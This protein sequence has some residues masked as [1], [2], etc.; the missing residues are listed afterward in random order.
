MNFDITNVKVK[1]ITEELENRFNN[2]DQYINYISFYDDLDNYEK[3]YL[4][5]LLHLQLNDLFSFLNSKYQPNV[6]G[7][8]NAE[9]SRDLIYISNK[10]TTIINIFKRYERDEVQL[11][12]SYLKALDHCKSF[13]RESYG[14]DIPIN[15]EKLHLIDYAPIFHFNKSNHLKT[16]NQNKLKLSKIG[17]GSYATVYK[18]KD[19]FYNEKFALKRAHKDLNTSEKERFKNEFE[20]LSKL[21]SP[22][23]IKAYNYF[24]EQLEYVME[25]ADITL[26][27]Y[28]SINNNKLNLKSRISLIKQ[29]LNAFKYLHSEKLLH[30]DISYN[31][32]LLKE[33]SD[34]TTVL[35]VSDFG[36]VKRPNST[37]T[38]QGTEIKGSLNDHTDLHLIG[39]DNYSIEHETF[40]LTQVVYFILTGRTNR[41]NAEKDPAINAFINKGTN[42]NKKERFSSVIEMESYLLKRVIPLIEKSRYSFVT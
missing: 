26:A 35:K 8:F 28:I 25:L 14:S 27:K 13:L 19:N 10:V 23:I 32:I 41:A 24:P 29:L 3:A 9:P 1:E 6:E 16:P 34:K 12:N 17:E 37:L 15:Y 21:N 4:F 18:Y 31:N 39:F 22:Y 5:S 30:R 40:A 36:M 42:P 2:T 38:N 7:H 11:E 33:Y 20:D